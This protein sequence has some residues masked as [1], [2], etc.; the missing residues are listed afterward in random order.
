[1]VSIDGATLVGA[2]LRGRTA[3]I[4]IRFVS[5]LVSV[6]RNRSGT[7][8]DGNPDKVSD[9]TDVWTFARDVSSRD[10]NWKVVATEAGQ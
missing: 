3:Q 9:V 1:F 8:I 10:P 6:T 5:K 4:T 7:V 2:E